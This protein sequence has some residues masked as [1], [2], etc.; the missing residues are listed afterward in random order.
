MQIICPP[1][2]R[3]TTVRKEM[4]N[5][6]EAVK[7][8]ILHLKK[9]L[10]VTDAEKELVHGGIVDQSGGLNT[11]QIGMVF[12]IFMDIDMSISAQRNGI[13]WCEHDSKQSSMVS[14]F[15]AGLM[16]TGLN[17]VSEKSSSGMNTVLSGPAWSQGGDI[18]ESGND[19]L[20][21]PKG[22]CSGPVNM[23]RGFG[24][25]TMGTP[26][27]VVQ[28]ALRGN[29]QMGTLT[30]TCPYKASGIGPGWIN[31]IP[32]GPAC[33]EAGVVGWAYWYTIQS[34]GHSLDRGFGKGLMF[35]SVHQCFLWFPIFYGPV[36]I[37]L[38]TGEEVPMGQTLFQMVQHGLSRDG[39]RLGEMNHLLQH[40]SQGDTH[41]L[42]RGFGTGSMFA[43]LQEVG[44]D[45]P[46]AP[47]MSH[48]VTQSIWTGAL[49]LD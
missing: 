27:Q 19:D 29:G 14:G 17:K 43:D 40:E 30:S 44:K 13:W 25:G 3:R 39:Q 9:A 2:M 10:Q 48:R 37:S 42:D 12:S 23:D 11:A 38:S 28:H 31:T 16:F 4:A 20:C 21:N 6:L 33:S 8:I 15:G 26:F 1:W 32:S 41:N 34:F 36:V 49:V 5:E 47:K 45:D 18:S 24:S 22:S 46:S 35:T 7:K